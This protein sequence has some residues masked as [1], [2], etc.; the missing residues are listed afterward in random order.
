M[1][2]LCYTQN[3]IGVGHFVRMLAIARGLGAAHEVHLVD[4]GRAVPHR[5][6]PLDPSLVPLPRLIREGGRLAAEE[7]RRSVADVLAERTR[8]LTEAVGRIGPEVVLVDHYPFGR[9]ELDA[10]I[11]DMIAAARRAHPGVSVISSVRD[12]LWS[13][14]RSAAPDDYERGVLARLEERFDGLLI[15]TDPAFWQLEEAFSRA[16]DITLPRHYTGVVVDRLAVSSPVSP[17]PE[18]YAVISCG[19]STTNLSFLL[20]AIEAFRRARAQV[21][22]MPLLVFPGPVGAADHAALRAASADGP[23]RL[24]GFSPDFPAWL[25]GSALSVSRA[26]YNTCGQ[27]LA[28]G[29]RSILVPNPENADQAPRA[30]RLAELG[31][32][33]VLQGDPPDADAI[34]SAI[35]TALARPPARHSLDLDG[36]AATRTV[37]EQRWLATKVR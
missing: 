9:W 12:N 27:I 26:G 2:I 37:L 7:S 31:L 32:V 23:C 24:F 14:Y 29:T 21:G 35:V 28:S 10:E 33:T 17:P 19:G 4:G 15:H 8:L 1:R 13:N 20:T 18:P 3:L 5:S 25:A 6:G 30:Q 34:A 16:G 36:V 22:S 11:A